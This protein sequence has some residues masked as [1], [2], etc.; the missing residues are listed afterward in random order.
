MSTVNATSST[1]ALTA[2]AP[3]AAFAND[4]LRS[5]AQ[6]PP[7]AALGRRPT[8][9]ARGTATP[10]LDLGAEDIDMLK[11]IARS[12]SR[13]EAEIEDARWLTEFAERLAPHAAT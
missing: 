5:V 11:L 8:V 7:S 4:L 3:I 13:G 1:P 9:P 6:G 10:P 12:V 2:P